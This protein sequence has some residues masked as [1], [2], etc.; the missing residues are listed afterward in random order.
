M[1]KS[2]PFT[3]V[4]TKLNAISAKAAKLQADIVAL[5]K[6]VA[7]ESKKAA[8]A[9]TATKTVA[10]VTKKALPAKKPAGK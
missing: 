10:K 5:E 7:V 6:L 3:A 1:P 4:A 9:P 8:A 2:N